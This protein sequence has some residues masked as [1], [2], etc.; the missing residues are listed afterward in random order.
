MHFV[1]LCWQKRH[2][3]AQKRF[4]WTLSVRWRMIHCWLNANFWLCARC[5][6]MREGVL[7]PSFLRLNR[8][9][10]L[11]VKPTHWQT[12]PVTAEPSGE[13]DAK[14]RWRHLSFWHR[15]KL[16]RNHLDSLLCGRLHPSISLC[17]HTCFAEPTDCAGSLDTQKHTIL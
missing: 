15:H 9:A 3:C 5:L 8:L 10:L 13:I 4:I 16:F 7:A 6:I 2:T 12:S 17:L 11:L 14:L 1:F